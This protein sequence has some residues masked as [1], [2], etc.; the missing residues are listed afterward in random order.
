MWSD[1]V[2]C[3][4]GSGH[5]NQTGWDEQSGF[6]DQREVKIGLGN[7]KISH[8]FNGLVDTINLGARVCQ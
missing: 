4:G 5:W 8:R 1:S 3:A 6:A 7:P 2:G